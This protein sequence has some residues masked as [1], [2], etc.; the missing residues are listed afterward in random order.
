MLVSGGTGSGKTTL[1]NIVSS[2][3]PDDERILTIEDSA[4]LQLN[5]S[6]LVAFESRP[7]DKFGKGGVDMGDLLHSA[8]RLRPDRIVVG[9]VRGG[10]AFYLMQAMNT[11]HGGSLATTPRQHAHRHAAPHRVAV[12]HVRRRAAHGG[13]ARPG[14]QRHQLR[15]LLRAPPRRQ[16]ARPSPSPRCSRSTRR[17][18]TAP[19]TSSSSRPVTQG[20]GR[21]HPRLPRAHRHHPQLRRQGARV[22]LH[23]PG[24]VLL[25]PGHLRRAAAAHLPGRRRRTRCAGRPRSSTARGAAGPLAVQEAVG[26]L[27]AEAPADA[28]DAKGGKPAAP[29]PV[30]T[31]PLLPMTC[32]M[33]SLD[34]RSSRPI[35]P[36][37]RNWVT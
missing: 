3:I 26:R 37:R 14:G 19:R 18:T 32:P 25:R 21:P 20:R 6:H 23:G 2:L 28:R 24:R 33:S 1:L 7:P 29:A 13:R 9:E 35:C 31:L 15:R 34:T 10:E 4:E 8:L 11:G 17:A 16:R 5:Q 27:R 30:P 36:P 12:P 22:R